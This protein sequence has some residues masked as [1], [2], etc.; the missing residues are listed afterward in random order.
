MFILDI[1]GFVVSTGI[2]I[3]TFIQNGY[4][5]GVTDIIGSLFFALLG[6]EL[7]DERL[8][9]RIEISETEI[10]YYQPRFTLACKWEN[11]EGLVRSV[12]GIALKFSE[13]EILSGRLIVLGLS[14]VGPWERLIPITPYLSLEN[15]QQIREVV[16]HHAYRFSTS[17][18]NMLAHLLR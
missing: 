6:L 12:Y 2:A 7:I 1:L 5:L 9:S 13:S 16:L 3:L 15:K 8:R 17:G 11:F 18:K 4:R 14:L 10:V